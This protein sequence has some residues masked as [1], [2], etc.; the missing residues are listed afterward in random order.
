MAIA[1]A[2]LLGYELTPNFAFP[3][4]ARSITEFWRRW[5][6]SLS[7]WLRDYLYIPLGGNRGSC[8]FTWRNLMLTMLLGGLWHGASWTFVIWGVLHGAALIVHREWTRHTE[9]LS[10]LFRRLMSAIAVPLTFYWILITWVF[11]R[12]RAV[13]DEETHALRATSFSVATDALRAICGFQGGDRAFA[14]PGLWLLIFAMLAALHFGNA[15]GWFANWWRP[16]PGW[17][18][19]TLLGA[20]WALALFFVQAKF[21]PFI[22]FQF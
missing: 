1:C 16:L 12:S 7:T 13:Y 4:F 10:G 3:Y 6:I 8:L 2:R 22:Y 14:R 11:F 21:K 9:H 20:G 19:A 17:L 18:F 5:H 15:R